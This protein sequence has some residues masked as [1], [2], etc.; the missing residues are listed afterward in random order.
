L[1]TYIY[2]QPL[3]NKWCFYYTCF[4][5]K[6]N[7]KTAMSFSKTNILTGIISTFL[8][9]SFSIS[10][11]S[12]KAADSRVSYNNGVITINLVDSNSNNKPN[13]NQPQVQQQ[14]YQQPVQTNTSNNGVITINLNGGNNNQTTNQVQQQNYQQLAQN[15]VYS[16]NGV[17]R[18]N[19]TGSNNQG[20]NQVQQN[21]NQQNNSTGDDSFSIPESSIYSLP[22]KFNS[23]DKINN[24]LASQGSV[25]ANYDMDFSFERDDDILTT[26]RRDNYDPAVTMASYLNKK[27][28]FADFV[29]KLSQTNIG[30]V[31]SIYNSNVC[32]NKQM[33]PAFI[34]G[35]IQRESGLV[36]GNNARRNNDTDFLL[37]RATGYFCF[38]TN[39]KS[40]GC[41]DENPSWRSY[42]GLFRQTYYMYRN[43]VLNSSRCDG[44]G[45][46]FSGNYYHSNN[47]ISVD[48]KNIK[49]DNGINCSLYIY[50]PHTAAQQSLQKVYNY[51]NN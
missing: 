5:I 47:V 45:I 22:N 23:A 19:L 11:L 32:F 12:V 8:L 2:R 33:N 18:I 4:V 49:L 20:S 37:D 13:N 14:T 41:W 29:W 15:N 25:L 16:N 30:N 38:E 51:I 10:P 7:L 24:Y 34:L 46:N 40:K 36:Y 1:L 44:Q 6:N 27:M 31:C 39:D 42:K 50:T 35:M 43:L 28:R 9:I 48:G 26:G 17:I 3:Y 21:S